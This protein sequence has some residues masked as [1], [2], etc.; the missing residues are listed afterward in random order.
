MIQEENLFCT[1]FLLSYCIILSPSNGD[2]NLQTPA[3]QS[4]NSSVN[5][6]NDKTQV[7]LTHLYMHD[8]DF[9]LSSAI[10]DTLEGGLENCEVF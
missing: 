8:G 10:L 1:D 3:V 2:G 9:F 5:I 4:T 7:Q 6:I